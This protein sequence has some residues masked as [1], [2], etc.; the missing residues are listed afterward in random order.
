MNLGNL[1]FVFEISGKT[2]N[3]EVLTSQGPWVKSIKENGEGE[4]KA[5]NSSRA[6]NPFLE[7]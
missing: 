2:A 6:S 5:G 1:L 3:S 4:I 7:V